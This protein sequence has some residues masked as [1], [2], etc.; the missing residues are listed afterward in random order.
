MGMNGATEPSSSRWEWQSTPL[1]N[2]GFTSL[3]PPLPLYPLYLVFGY[4]SRPSVRRCRRLCC[5]ML[6]DM[7][8]DE[9]LAATARVEVVAV[10]VDLK[11]LAA[12][13]I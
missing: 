9:V 1:K 12:T 2:A 13:A 10:A 3:L 11:K 7:L 6:G 8:R 4:L 5:E